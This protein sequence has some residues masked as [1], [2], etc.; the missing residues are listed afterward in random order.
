MSRE[1]EEVN[2]QG[3]RS[4]IEGP[5]SLDGVGVDDDVR[6][7]GF[8]QG[9][10]LGDRLDGADF[11][12]RGHEREQNRHRADRFLELRQIDAALSVHR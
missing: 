8:G 5:G 12:V 10:G 9:R 6:V 11:V 4:D 3:I 7:L 2:P 1:A